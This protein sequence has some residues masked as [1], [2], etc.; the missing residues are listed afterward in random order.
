MDLPSSI[1]I[2]ALDFV[3]LPIASLTLCV[4]I[5]YIPTFATILHRSGTSLVAAV[6]CTRHVLQLHQYF[7]TEMR[8]GNL[9]V[10][11][12]LDAKSSIVYVGR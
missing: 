5:C 11:L 8:G 1:H 6:A 12:Q 10:N 3:S 7:T 2:A 9:L 4:A